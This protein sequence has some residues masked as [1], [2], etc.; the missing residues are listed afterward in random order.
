MV[1]KAQKLL[2]RLRETKR[3]WNYRDLHAVLVDAGFDFRDSGHRVYRHPE[4]P[5]LGS[6]PIP[7]GNDLAPGYARDVERLV[8][9]VARR[10]KA[11]EG[12]REEGA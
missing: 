11:E 1:S 6:Y 4:Y 9:G 3:G 7:R 5:D 2:G 12:K 8:D 10:K